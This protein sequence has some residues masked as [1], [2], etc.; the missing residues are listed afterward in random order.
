MINECSEYEFRTN[1]N[2]F[3]SKNGSWIECADFA[4]LNRSRN[5]KI[6]DDSFDLIKVQ[7]RALGLIC[8][9]E[10]KRTASDTS[11][12]WKLTQYGDYLLTQLMAIRK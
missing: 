11:T 9:S 3:L 12:Y 7:F 2:S 5:F 8:L 6:S 1:L 4:S 10:R